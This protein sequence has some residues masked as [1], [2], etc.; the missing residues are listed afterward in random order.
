[1][2]VRKGSVKEKKEL[3]FGQMIKE[4][5]RRLHFTQP[6]LA[7]LMNVNPNTVKNWERDQTKPDHSL[8]PDLCGLLNIRLHELY[9][10][11]AG[12]ELSSL[13]SRIIANLR[14]LDMADRRVVDKLVSAL[15][16]ERL[17]D[18]Q[19]MLK[20]SFALFCVDPGASA[21]G[22]GVDV[23]EAPPEYTF[24]RKNS[25][26]AKADAVV[27][28]SD[29]SM[30]PVY[31]DGDMVYYRRCQDALPGMDVIVDTDQGAV[32]KRVDSD[33][34]LYSVNPAYPCP[35][36]NEQNSYRIRGQVL[37]VVQSSD[38]VPPKDASL[39]EEMFADEIREFKE[40]Y[41]I[42]EWE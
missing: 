6:E 40:K 25:V 3:L 24:L 9:Q 38:H 17:L 29:S 31:Y 1:M 18:Q 20:E 30:E 21:A 12:E 28:V 16:S 42:Q 19:V 7:D 15:H 4:H 11:E 34:T 22:V 14:D 35:K 5:R 39:I 41:G 32:I 2:A 8:I 37:G 26:N 33:R 27:R 10:M 36:G 13:E 23:P